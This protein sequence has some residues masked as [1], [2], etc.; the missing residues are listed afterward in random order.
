MAKVAVFGTEIFH[1]SHT[2]DELRALLGAAAQLTL[3]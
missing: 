3:A 1:G 2:A